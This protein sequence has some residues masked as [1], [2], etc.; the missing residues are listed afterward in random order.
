MT[1]DRDQMGVLASAHCG[2]RLVLRMKGILMKMTIFDDFLTTNDDFRR[3]SL[4]GRNGFQSGV[5][6]DI[7]ELAFVAAT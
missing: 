7:K 1:D 2:G 6:F 5:F 4:P 3:W